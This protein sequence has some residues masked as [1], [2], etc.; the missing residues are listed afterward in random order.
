L[1]QAPA[2]LKISGFI[3]WEL[4]ATSST[5]KSVRT[6]SQS[7]MVKAIAQSSAWTT[8]AGRTT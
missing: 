6:N 5:D 2:S 1:P 3:E 4:L 8:A 7:S